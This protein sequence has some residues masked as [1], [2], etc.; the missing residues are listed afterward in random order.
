MQTVMY[1]HMVWSVFSCKFKFLSFH[2]FFNSILHHT[3]LHIVQAKL[4]LYL[5]NIVIFI[6]IENNGYLENLN[7]KKFNF[8]DEFTVPLN[9]ET[10]TLY[11]FDEKVS[12]SVLF[13]AKKNLIFG[14]CCGNLIEM[15]DL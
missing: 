4:Q 8:L 9:W 7:L 13:I 14:N 2:F 6:P 12:F 15:K 11:P 3:S 5:K 10:D 1:V